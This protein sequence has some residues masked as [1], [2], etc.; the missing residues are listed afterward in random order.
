[1]FCFFS[2]HFCLFIVILL[3]KMKQNF[4]THFNP[5]HHHQWDLNIIFH[6]CLNYCFSNN[7]NYKVSTEQ[8]ISVVIIPDI[9]T[10][11]LHRL[12]LH[13]DGQ[14]IDLRPSVHLEEKVIRV[15][16]TVKITTAI[17]HHFCF[18]CTPRPVNAIE[19]HSV[20][21]S[22]YNA[23]TVGPH[24]CSCYHSG[25]RSLRTACFTCEL[26]FNQIL[27]DD[28][29]TSYSYLLNR[30]WISRGIA[31]IFLWNYFWINCPFDRIVSLIKKTNKQ[32]L[33]KNIYFRV[34]AIPWE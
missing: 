4:K 14:I 25:H 33:F 31:H 9:I 32:M 23:Q 13:P 27:W 12:P 28:S 20:I 10:F 19:V 8:W 30:R 1:M 5:L 34:S 3:T 18:Q 24:E 17:I 22:P 21:F 16:K 2:L 15:N 26:S 7:I 29:S 11:A 6:Y